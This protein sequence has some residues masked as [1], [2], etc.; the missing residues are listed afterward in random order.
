MLPLIVD[1]SL[2]PRARNRILSPL[3]RHLLLIVLVKA[4]VLTGL[5]FVFIK[6]NKVSMDAERMEQRMGSGTASPT[7]EKP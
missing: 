6:P 5:W 3:G 2:K 1:M 4:L 7:K